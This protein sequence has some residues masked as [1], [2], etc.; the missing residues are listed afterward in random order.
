MRTSDDVQHIGCFNIAKK[1]TDAMP[2]KKNKH[3][4]K[5]KDKQQ[6]KKMPPLPLNK[7]AV[8][9]AEM[10]EQLIDTDLNNNLQVETN[11]LMTSSLQQSQ[12][13]QL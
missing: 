8:D 11:T 12:A 9:E 13:T 3:K 7:P 5:D 1:Q 4:H 10:L 2:P 6:K